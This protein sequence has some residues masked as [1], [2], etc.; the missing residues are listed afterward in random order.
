MVTE[1]TK[2]RKVYKTEAELHIRLVD[3]IYIRA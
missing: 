1:K 2:R 3:G